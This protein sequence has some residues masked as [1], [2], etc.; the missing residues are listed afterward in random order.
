MNN[1]RNCK[2]SI[3]LTV[4]LALICF[5]LAQ[6]LEIIAKSRRNS[7]LDTFGMVGGTLL[8]TSTPMSIQ[9]L[10]TMVRNYT[11]AYAVPKLLDKP[12]GRLG[13]AFVAGGLVGGF[14]LGGDGF[15]F[16]WNNRAMLTQGFNS[17]AVR[18]VQDYG[19]KQG[20]DRKLPGLSNLAGNLAGDFTFWGA[21]KAL[22]V[23]WGTIG[24]KIAFADYGK[25]MYITGGREF[26]LPRMVSIPYGSGLGL[27][28][29]ILKLND[30]NEL[31][32]H[33]G[34][35]LK[36]HIE[37]INLPGI[38]S[39]SVFRAGGYNQ[40]YL[41]MPLKLAK[42][43]FQ[44][45]VNS[46]LGGFLKEKF[47]NYAAEG[48]RLGYENAF[49]LHNPESRF[50]SRAMGSLVS[51]AFSGLI[52]GR[53]LGRG[54]IQGAASGIVSAGL[55]NI[56][57]YLQKEGLSPHT[58][59]MVNLGLTASL[60]GIFSPREEGVSRVKA[61]DSIIKEN[62]R[63]AIGNFGTF[64]LASLTPTGDLYYFRPPDASFY[65][66]MHDFSRTVDG[67]PNS[68]WSKSDWKVY[69]TT[70]KIPEHTI[71]LGN[72]LA[73]RLSSALHY[74]AVD[75]ITS[76]LNNDR[77]NKI[78]I[79]KIKEIEKIDVEKIEIPGVGMTGLQSLKIEELEGEE[80]S[81]MPDLA[82]EVKK[83]LD[84]QRMHGGIEDINEVLLANVP[85]VND[86]KEIASVSQP[87]PGSNLQSSHD[88]SD[89]AGSS[90][91][92]VER[93]RPIIETNSLGGISGE[94]P[95]RWE[96]VDLKPLSPNDI[97]A[98]FTKS[99]LTSDKKYLI[100]PNGQIYKKVYD[101]PNA[102]QSDNESLPLVSPVTLPSTKFPETV[103]PEYRDVIRPTQ[104][105]REARRGLGKAPSWALMDKVPLKE[106]ESF[107]GRSGQDV[108]GV[109]KRGMDSVAKARV[110]R[111]EREMPVADVLKRADESLA[112]SRNVRESIKQG[113]MPVSKISERANESVIRSREMRENFGPLINP[114]NV[115]GASE[116]PGG[117]FMMMSPIVRTETFT[118]SAGN[119]A[120][121]SPTTPLERMEV[122]NKYRM[123]E[124]LEN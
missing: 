28:S 112:R 67:L 83:S 65:S 45:W 106:S 74:Q 40:R 123:Q 14:S 101:N 86:I 111:K 95:Y 61:I 78:K 31:V 64:G 70:G 22:K 29:P 21:N 24:G 44:P 103:R 41:P 102:I 48:V 52:D 35:Q 79:E 97:P 25:G 20:W 54:M 6:P 121:T 104:S 49:S 119:G 1:L 89:L 42:I 116:S 92:G 33:G 105:D 115:S 7:G 96:L 75:N 43:G 98:G 109:L 23:D 87:V 85:K 108:S 62:M 59:A 99:I 84:Q 113:G 11:I 9:S 30:D 100:H 77:L 117:A 17:M 15:K 2:L 47:T 56:G 82:K 10:S 37:H 26:N 18:G 118:P 4:L 46:S 34:G 38:D 5:G 122:F 8:A 68:S 107:G 114:I 72:A 13:S 63:Q 110:F 120:D 88:S 80:I 27:A 16:K 57:N 58:A 66:S 3:R 81:K 50:Y 60:K 76:L 124:H 93:P 36:G 53:G 12:L 90:Q 69:D 91:P 19:Y 32:W 55:G 71:G 51:G 73:S 94:Q 39:S